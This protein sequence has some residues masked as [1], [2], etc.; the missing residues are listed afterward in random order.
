[1]DKAQKSSDTN[2]NIPYSETFRIDSDNLYGP[3]TPF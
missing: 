2:C 1:M 3:G